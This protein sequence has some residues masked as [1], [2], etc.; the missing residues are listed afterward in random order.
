MNHT[1]E[2]LFVGAQERGVRLMPVNDAKSIVED[3]GLKARE[4]FV[5]VEH[6]ELGESLKYPGPPYRFSETPWRISKRAPLIG[7]HNMEIYEKELGF[8]KEQ[9]G[10]LKVANVI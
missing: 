1:R 8:T 10:I 6:P 9:I 5:D 7:E 4:Y 3:I 2:E